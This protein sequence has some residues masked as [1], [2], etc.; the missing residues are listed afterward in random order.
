MKQYANESEVLLAFA[1]PL[2]E[3]A[4]VNGDARRMQM[5]LSLA[6]SVWNVVVMETLQG[7]PSASASSVQTA[8]AIF[9]Q[10]AVVL[11][12]QEGAA[13]LVALFD[14][15]VQRKRADFAE[16]LWLVR[17]A[18]CVQNQDGVLQVE[19]QSSRTATS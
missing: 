11:M 10:A 2:M 14:Q 13:T 17:S 1:E 7:G 4:A 12:Q 8:R 19:V 9:S 16:H 5:V 15:L 3:L 6:K 18:T